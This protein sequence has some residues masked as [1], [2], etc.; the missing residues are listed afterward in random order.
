MK[1][2]VLIPALAA[3]AALASCNKM[4][5]STPT[6]SGGPCG[7]VTTAAPSSEVEQLKQYINS[8]NIAAEADSRGFYYS[9]KRAGDTSKPTICSTVQVNY[10]GRLT[11]GTRFDAGSQV[12]FG[13]SNL[14]VGWQEGIPLIGT[15]GSITL[16]LPPSLAYGARVQDNIPANSILVF[17]IELLNFR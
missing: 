3:F 4:D 5:S 11:N 9:I 2:F 15:G 17:D 10:S 14:I 8:N 7:T 1:R 12:T 13:L 16:Y 6:V